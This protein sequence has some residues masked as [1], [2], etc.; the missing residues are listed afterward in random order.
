LLHAAIDTGLAG[1]A[2]EEAAGFVRTCSR[3]WFESGFD[4]AAEDPLLIQRFGE[5]A[6]QVRAA[7]ALVEAAARAVDAARADLTD[8]SAAEASIAVASAKA[9]AA[10]AAVEVSSALF[11]VAGTRA[12]LGSLN[13]HQRR[14][15]LGP[16]RRRSPP[17]GIG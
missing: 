5:L 10:G 4:T 8:A 16:G 12:A 11:E 13:L 2:L 3:P 9:F 7:D 14:Q 1:A 6:L 15:P 17:A